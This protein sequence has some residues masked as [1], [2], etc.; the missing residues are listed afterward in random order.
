MRLNAVTAGREPSAV[1]SASIV[2]PRAA[3]RPGENISAP[4][5]AGALGSNPPGG[6]P[7]RPGCAP[8]AG[9][10]PSGVR[11]NPEPT[12]PSVTPVVR[13]V[14]S[15]RGVHVEALRPGPI[16]S[17]NDLRVVDVVRLTDQ[18]PRGHVDH[19]HSAR[20]T[21]SADAPS[22]LVVGFYRRDFERRR[23]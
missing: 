22:A 19:V 20:R 12:F 16:G 15:E 17:A 4:H 7:P 1:A 3:N 5:G 10:A 13:G 8:P 23:V 9:H 14:A 18:Q 2:T 21:A 11:V 6:G